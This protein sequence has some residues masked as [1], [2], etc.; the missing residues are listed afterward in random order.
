M[1]WHLSVGG[2]TR[3]CYES[4]R[5]ACHDA[6]I[7]VRRVARRARPPWIIAR[8]PTQFSGRTLAAPLPVVKQGILFGIRRNDQGQPAE[9]E[10]IRSMH[11]EGGTSC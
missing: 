2:L 5:F 8:S 10:I 6:L 11:D 7:H 3:P 1:M 9:S 4:K